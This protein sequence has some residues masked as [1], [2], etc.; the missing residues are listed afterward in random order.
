MP[1]AVTLVELRNIN[2]LRFL[3]RNHSSLSRACLSDRTVRRRLLTN[4][5]PLA[6]QRLNFGRGTTIVGWG[7]SK[8]ENMGRVS[9]GLLAFLFCASALAAFPENT[10]CK[11]DV[12]IP[13]LPVATCTLPACATGSDCLPPEMDR[14]N[15]AVDFAEPKIQWAQT[16]CPIGAGTGCWKVEFAFTLKLGATDPSG[17]QDIGLNLRKEFLNQNLVKQKYFSPAIRIDETG[18]YV[19]SGSFSDFVPAGGK[20]VLSVFEICAR[21]RMGNEGCVYPDHALNR[22]TSKLGGR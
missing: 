5:A 11:K 12:S 20:V 7:N 18:R 14:K 6:R 10:L 13:N 2:D 9:T 15:V 1:P 22:I 16:E 21:D 17:V 19:V 3:R 4:V 8:G